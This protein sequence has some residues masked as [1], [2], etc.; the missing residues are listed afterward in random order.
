MVFGKEIRFN[1]ITKKGR[2][3][4]VTL[5]HGVSTGPIQGIE[6]I[7]NTISK[8]EKGGATSILIHK[9]LMKSVP[10]NIKTG[11]IVHLSASTN[12][13]LTPNRKILATN[14]EEAI[15]LGAD[16]VSVHINVGG[17]EEP[18]M[19]EQLGIISGECERWGMPCI[20]MMYPRGEN[21][22]NQH[23]PE[24]VAHAARIGAE[25]GAD[26]VKTVYTG[27]PDSF[28][29]VV[30]KCP[31]PIAIAGG[32]KAKTDQDVFEMVKGAMDAGSIGVT[33]GRNIFQHSDPTKMVV[34]LT[35]LVMDN[36]SVTE[37]V[38]VLSSGV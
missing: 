35:A 15:R 9:G 13:G 27:D 6:N 31:V 16:A 38:E 29:D 33:F 8:V 11:I 1:R 23:D 18:E 22:T 25:L 3:V 32:P 21:I 20:A 28:K 10:Q 5:D 2:I 26:L 17:Q 14:V 7:N 24:K 36:L 19:L 4:C 34:A 30:K 12:L 37:A